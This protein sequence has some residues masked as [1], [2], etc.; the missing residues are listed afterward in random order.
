MLGCYDATAI[1]FWKT[2]EGMAVEGEVLRG[3]ISTLAYRGLVARPSTGEG[4][5]AMAG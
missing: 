2:V 3:H 4:G 5:A 1:L